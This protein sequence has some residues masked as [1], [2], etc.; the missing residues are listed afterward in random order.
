MKEWPPYVIDERV[1]KNWPSIILVDYRV[2]LLY[3][4]ATYYLSL[5][6]RN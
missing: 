4:I 3:T 5:G 2:G 6:K 1:V